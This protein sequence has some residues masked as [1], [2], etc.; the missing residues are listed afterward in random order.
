MISILKFNWKTGVFKR[1]IYILATLPF[2]LSK[3]ELG[4]HSKSQNLVNITTF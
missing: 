3:H 4:V 1:R 2:I